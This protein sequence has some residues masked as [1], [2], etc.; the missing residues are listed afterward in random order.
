MRTTSWKYTFGTLACAAVLA[1]A[2]DII[3]QSKTKAKTGAKTAAKKAPP[4]KATAKKATAKKAA[5]KKNAAAKPETLVINLE[6]PSGIAIH[7]KTG[8]VFVATR[9]GVY[10]YVPKDDKVFVE[11]ESEASA[12][13]KTPDVYGKGSYETYTKFNIGPLGLTFMDDEHLVVGDGSRKDGDELVRV[14]KITG[15]PQKVD[16]GHKEGSAAFTLGPIKAGEKSAKGEGN[17]YG[18]AVAAGAIFVTCNGDDTKGWISKSEI[19][20]GK[21][22]K[23]VPTIATKTA[24]GVD[25]PAPITVTLDGKQL[26][27]GQMGEMNVPGDSLLTFYD[28][29]TGKLLKKYETGLS[30]IAGLAYSPKTKKLYATDFGWADAANKAKATKEKPFKQIGGL[31]EL[32]IKGDKVEKKRILNLDKPA[33]IAFADDGKLYITTFGSKKGS[34]AKSGSTFII[35]P[36]GTLMNSEINFYNMGRNIDEMMRKF[37]ANLYLSRKADEGCP[38]KWKDDGDITLKPSAKM[39]GKVHEA[40]NDH[41]FDEPFT[42]QLKNRFPR[43]ENAAMSVLV[44]QPAPDFKATAVM[45]DGSFQEISLSDY[46]GKYA[47]LFFYPLD[48][49]FVC[50]TEI[51]AFSDRAAEFEELGVQLLGCSIDSHFSHLAWRNTPRNT[52]GL[53]EITYPLIA[54]LNKEIAKAYDVLLPDGIALRGLFLIDKEGTVR[55][56]VVNDLPLGRSVDEALRMVR[57]LQYF[58][59][60]GEVCPADWKEGSLTIKPDPSGSQEYFSQANS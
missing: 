51:I 42:T 5:P 41:N 38:S 18:V 28:P 29:K 39:V 44:A 48:F 24:T 32:T 49:T 10:R 15:G 27:V 9:Y 47:I 21:P 25:A 7:K 14:Y 1:S 60:N 13:K 22:G 37:K 33:A 54:D 59:A 34:A 57:A 46:K 17:F 19:K 2:G 6:N 3:A 31:Y 20:D 11:I 26:V 56:Q 50:P 30:D 52:G 35:N 4:K 8:H 16:V 40:L 43:K 53:G 45:A 12:D 36:E 58:E 55:H 23:L